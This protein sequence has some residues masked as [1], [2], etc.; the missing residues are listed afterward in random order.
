MDDLTLTSLSGSKWIPKVLEELIYWACVSI[1]PARAEERK[2]RYLFA[3][4][5]CQIPLLRNQ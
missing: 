4:G 2:S 1:K 5:S 3:L